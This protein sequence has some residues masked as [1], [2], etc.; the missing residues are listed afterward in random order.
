[1]PS[2]LTVLTA[3]PFR[4]RPVGTN[5]LRRVRVA[6]P[7]PIDSTD[8]IFLMLRR[9]RG[10]L[11]ILVVIFA[12]S[13]LGLTLIPG[14][15][16]AGHR[17]HMSLFDAFYVVS[18]TGTTIGFGEL[19]TTFTTAQRMWMTVTIYAT[20]TGW[21]YSIGAVFSLFQDAG[22]RR[23]VN[24]QRFRRSVRHLRE[25]FYLVVGYG[26]A[27]RELAAS[28][29]RAGKRLVVLDQSPE[30][31]DL[32]T[33]DQLRSDVPALVADPRQPTTL[34]LAGLGSPHL[35][36]VMA[37][38]NDDDVNLSVVMAAHLLREDAHVV[39][40]C[41]QR[42]NL[43]RMH[44]FAPDAVINPY[45]RYG[46]YLLLGLGHPTTAR[47][48]SWL[49]QEPGSDLP[50]QL[51]PRLGQGRWVVCADSSFGQEI[52]HDLE[53]AGHDVSTFDPRDGLPDVHDAVGL[54]AGTE[55]DTT[56]LS[57][58]AAAR[59]QNPDIYLSVRQRSAA[60][61]SLMQSFAP[62]SV[63]VAT[64][65]VA[66][67]AFARAEAPA[68][69][70]FIEYAMQQDDEWAAPVLH[71]VIDRLGEQT[72]V[73]QA[74]TLDARTAPAVCRW[75]GAGRDLTLGQLLAD[76]NERTRSL[77]LVATVLVRDHHSTYLPPL[78]TPLRMGDTLGLLTRDHDFDIL[79]GNLTNDVGVEYL[80][81]G[82]DAPS[83]WLGHLLQRRR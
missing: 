41:S 73:A 60:T 22:F 40:R 15:D 20:V 51:A 4:R 43:E 67:E 33:T 16:A 35:A 54:V 1:M 23:A 62:D 81:T 18:Y 80:A 12:T 52:A 6:V 5:E 39:A 70:H 74:I 19:P 30:R 68:F 7:D 69:W 27:G 77:A 24:H 10:P 14:V 57:V 45:D 72:P 76:P 55:S 48:V 50:P 21:A 28:L 46:S 8:A 78:D 25:P 32:L 31:I 37:V 13:M 64:E 47:L 79:N 65:L 17:Y 66:S 83:T 61:R 29:D 26:N 59:L 36:G 56:N 82:V 2:P 42:E 71:Q 75:L 63:F 44:D 49:L 34:G 11:I 9:M 3:R 58:A 53:Q 38:T